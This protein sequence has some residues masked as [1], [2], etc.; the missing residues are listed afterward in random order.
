VLLFAP[1]GALD[2]FPQGA[3]TAVVLGRNAS[4]PEDG[5]LGWAAVL[6]EAG[7]FY[8]VVQGCPLDV[9][10]TID[11]FFTGATTLFPAPGS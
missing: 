8:G 1:S 10:G 4:R 9:P 11:W 3:T 7:N 2:V 5:Q 6:D